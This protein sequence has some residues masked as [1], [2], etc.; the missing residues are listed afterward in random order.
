MEDVPELDISRDVMMMV[1]HRYAKRNTLKTIQES[2]EDREESESKSFVSQN[3][4]DEE[5][6]KTGLRMMFE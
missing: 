3:E 2:A 5:N 4:I 6:R 1:S